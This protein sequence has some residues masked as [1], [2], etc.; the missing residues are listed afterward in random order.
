M[1]VEEVWGE[2]NIPDGVHKLY[3][4]LIDKLNEMDDIQ[5]C[6][7]GKLS[8]EALEE[9]MDKAKNDL[10][11]CIV[12]IVRTEDEKFDFGR[13]EEL[14]GDDDFWEDIEGETERRTRDFLR[15]GNLRRL[16]DIFRRKCFETA[17]EMSYSEGEVPEFVA[18]ILNIDKEDGLLL[19]QILGF[20]EAFI[21]ERSLSK[22]IF[23]NNFQKKYGFS[24]KDCD[25]IWDLFQADKEK[26]EKIAVRRR[27][28]DIDY[29]MSRI[30]ER[31]G[32][33]EELFDMAL[34]IVLDMEEE[35]S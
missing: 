7:A 16:D 25:V 9:R 32:N 29:K 20:S 23:G 17:F 8:G 35:D 14:F 6:G 22:R 34:D 26:I 33:L 24:E 28:V 5:K 19:F 11:Q 30:S 13:L 4:E 1:K 10:V 2:K 31:L 12:K 18:K 21:I 27:L 3:E 15:T